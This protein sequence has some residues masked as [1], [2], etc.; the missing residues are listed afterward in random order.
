[1]L[2]ICNTLSSL[3]SW[4]WGTQQP[5]PQQPQPLPATG[6]NEEGN[7]SKWV[8]EEI[9]KYQHHSEE[10]KMYDLLMN[11]CLRY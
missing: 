4:I 7:K 6:D 3:S 10:D 9:T 1:M 8:G 11:Q 2:S 5:Q